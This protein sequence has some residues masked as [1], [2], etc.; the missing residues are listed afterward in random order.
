[1]LVN[2]SRLHSAAGPGRQSM[3]SRRQ[4][5]AHSNGRLSLDTAA[6]TTRTHLRLPGTLELADWR[7]IGEQIFLISDSSTWWL[8]DWLVFGEENYP[9]RYRRAISETGLDYG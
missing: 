1:M 3:A 2:A 8:G 9:G 6:M 5:G 4:N 7:R